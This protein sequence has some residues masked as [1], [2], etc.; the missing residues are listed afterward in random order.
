LSNFGFF[1]PGNKDSN[2]WLWDSNLLALPQNWQ[3]DSNLD[4]RTRLTT[5]LKPIM[6]IAYVFWFCSSFHIR[7][8]SR[9]HV[10]P[11]LLL[12]LLP[13]PPSWPRPHWGQLGRCLHPRRRSAHGPGVRRPAARGA[14][15]LVVSP[16]V[17]SLGQSPLL[18]RKGRRLPIRD[19]QGG[20]GAA[21]WLEFSRF[22]DRERTEAGVGEE[23]AAEHLPADGQQAGDEAVWV[24]EGA[25]SREGQ[26]KGGR[27]L[28]HTSVLKFQVSKSVTCQFL[29]LVVVG[30]Y[31]KKIKNTL[32]IIIQTASDSDQFGYQNGP[33]APPAPRWM[34]NFCL[35]SV[36][37][38][39]CVSV[40]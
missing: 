13:P 38:C 39:A 28:D 20:A 15:T 22:L 23:P 8:W 30:S 18:L 19:A 21:V 4:S 26:A 40:I 17:G 14:Q 32:C 35:V 25:H 10:R 16:A 36:C 29:M 24:K 5:T 6:P 31:I 9:S 33:F 1:L 11:S 12:R 37:L 2:P 7:R 3:K 34:P 27:T